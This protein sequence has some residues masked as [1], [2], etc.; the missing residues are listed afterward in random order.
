M[1]STTTATAPL[2]TVASNAR[3]EVSSVLGAASDHARSVLGAAGDEL[4]EQAASR[5]RQLG[6]MLGQ[7]SDEFDRMARECDTS[8]PAGRT[9]STLADAT[10]QVARTLEQRGPQ[11]IATDLSAFARRRPGVF[12]MASAAAGFAVARLMRSTDTAAVQEAIGG[13]SGNGHQ[14]EHH[15]PEHHQREVQQR[16][17]HQPDLSGQPFGTAPPTGPT[18]VTGATT[19]SDPFE[20]TGT[21]PQHTTHG[22]GSR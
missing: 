12:L 7:A 10:G 11:G 5:S 20:P 6:Q 22:E 4:H 21:S 1:S 15:Q 2:E 18:G 14:P 17:P 9:V 13:S 19:L 3:T 16:Q 8:S